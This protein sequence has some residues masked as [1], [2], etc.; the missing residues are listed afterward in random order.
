MTGWTGRQSDTFSVKW[1][2]LHN[3]DGDGTS[4]ISKEGV[5]FI[6]HA[7]VSSRDTP[8]AVRDLSPTGQVLYKQMSSISSETVFVP[9]L[10]R[11]RN[12]QRFNCMS[13]QTIDLLGHFLLQCHLLLYFCLFLFFFFATQT[14]LQQPNDELPHRLKKKKQ[15]A[16]AFLSMTLLGELSLLI[17]QPNFLSIMLY[18][19]F[20]QKQHQTIQARLQAGGNC[21]KTAR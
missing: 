5:I 19:Y 13:P 1:G 3:W 14:N 15:N 20:R 11:V 12:P 10:Q 18:E 21:F 4:S 16:L 6:D 17:H 8:Q 2:H 9:S 7:V